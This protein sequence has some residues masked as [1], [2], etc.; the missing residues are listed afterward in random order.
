L[1]EQRERWLEELSAHVGREEAVTG[2][3]GRMNLVAIAA[4][5][6][7]ADADERTQKRIQVPNW[8]SMARDLRDTT[9]YLGPQ[10][11][12]LV[13]DA[14]AALI[15]SIDGLFVEQQDE[16]GQAR[17]SIDNERRP[18]VK[19]SAAQ[20]FELLNDD[21]MLIAMWRDLIAACQNPSHADYSYDRVGF[22]RDNVVALQEHRRQDPGHWGLIKTAVEIL[23][24]YGASVQRAQMH[25]GDPPFGFDP[26]QQEQSTGLTME[27][28]LDLAERWIVRRP[29]TNDVVVWFRINN[30]Y[31][32]NT[33]CSDHANISFY[34]AQSL[35]S[36]ILDHN[37]A[38]GHYSVVPEEL[39]TDKI[40]AAQSHLD[41][42][43]EY[44]GFEHKPGLVYARIALHEVESHRAV[45][46]A[47]H[48]LDCLLSLL[49]PPEH[50]WTVLKG[51]LVFDGSWNPRPLEWGPKRDRKPWTYFG[52][53]HVARDLRNLGGTGLQV[54]P[55]VAHRLTAVRQ[56][57][58]ALKAVPR[59][60]PE[61]IVMAAVRAIEH[62]NTW[63]TRGRKQ[64]TDFITSY[65]LDGFTRVSFL[66]RALEHTAVAIVSTR[67]NRSPGAPPV[68]ELDAIREAVSEGIGGTN[69][70][71]EIA[72][73]QINL[74][75]TIY[76]EHPLA[77]PLAEL[78]AE[79]QSGTSIGRAMDEERER[80]M[81]RVARLTRSRN[82]AIHGGPLSAAACES[83]ADFA[84]DLA[85]Q[86][87]NVVTQAIV[88]SE[89]IPEYMRAI[90][91][92]NRQ[93]NEALRRTGDRRHF[94]P[95]TESADSGNRL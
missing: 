50:M 80:V 42:I 57:S 19:A 33:D 9:E 73:R 11:Y 58:E 82:A 49:S 89:S 88:R 15:D 30:A 10:T 72:M 4:E 6:V 17:R 93:R 41:E 38:R 91:D 29:D 40:L 1:F 59:T 86:A 55:D 22:L 18:P 34:S 47:R 75:K 51:H 35:A 83:I 69:F 81:A 67:P 28:R 54:T 52:N 94:L 95:D 79:L 7:N 2:S 45:K 63:T 60:D 53:D 25:V 78:D 46:E 62:C 92:E 65:L 31:I 37:F 84:R 90:R 5:I 48:Q 56:L 8:E 76:A 61:G 27:Q 21:S 14:S 36:G 70:N 77:R 68:P 85:D 44:H 16:R 12:C 66:K 43:T 24:D 74:L 71:L 20:L 87:L 64:W 26:R 3:S 13:R 32:T 39:L 23:F